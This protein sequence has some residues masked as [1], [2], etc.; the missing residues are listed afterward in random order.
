MAMEQERKRGLRKKEGRKE[1]RSPDRASL[2]SFSLSLFSPSLPPS[3]PLAPSKS[4]ESFLRSFRAFPPPLCFEILSLSL[5][6]SLF[7][8]HKR[9]AG[10]ER[11]A[12]PPSCDRYHHTDETTTTMAK[13]VLNR[14]CVRSME[15][16]RERERESNRGS[17]RL[18]WP[19]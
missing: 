11:G 4:S 18:A 9:K 10:A 14:E 6:P 8:R 1:G 7:L 12:R 3:L 5:S 17:D 15:R 2:H 16:E 13:V 19:A